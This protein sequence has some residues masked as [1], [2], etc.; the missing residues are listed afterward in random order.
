MDG[1]VIKNACKS[2]SKMGKNTRKN[3]LVVEKMVEK[4]WIE[5]QL[6]KLIKNKCKKVA[7]K[8]IKTEFENFV[9]KL[10]EKNA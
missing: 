10:V 4:K 8:M 7:G 2:C 6:I 1:K 9:Q 5:M 3:W